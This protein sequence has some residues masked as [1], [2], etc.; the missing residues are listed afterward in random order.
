MPPAWDSQLRKAPEADGTIPAG[1]GLGQGGAVLEP[2][3][4]DL[5]DTGEASGSSLQQPPQ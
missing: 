5:L 2:L 3:E 4:L 1:L